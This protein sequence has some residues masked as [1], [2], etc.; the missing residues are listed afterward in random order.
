[1]EINQQFIENRPLSYS[2]LKAFRKSPKHYIN[3][4]EQPFIDTPATL[5]GKVVDCLALT[6]ELFEKRF[7]EY[8]KPDLRSTKGKEENEKMLSYATANKLTLVSPDDVKTAKICVESLLSTKTSADLLKAKKRAQ[9]KLSW[10][11]KEN[12]LPLL[13]YADFE[14]FM[15]DELFVVD[16][17]TASD[18]DPDIWQRDFFKY[19]YTIQAGAYLD[20]YHKQFYKFPYFVFLVVETKEPFNVS[21]NFVDSK[22]VEF[23]KQE[24]YGTL[25]AF[26]YCMDNN[27]FKQ[28]YEFRTQTMDYF[29]IQKP[30]Y[31]KNK[32]IGFEE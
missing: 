13:G 9:I 22:M 18:A 16:L 17:K 15:W 14:S 23:C 28:G 10:R 5:L 6:P 27:L 24:F 12:N 3:Y 11:N 8:V 4:L 32:F 21:V 19:D 26:R 31:I 2:S 30:A 20:G 1:M 7:L 29:S 25:K